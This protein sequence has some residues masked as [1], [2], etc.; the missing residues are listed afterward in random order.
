MMT[1]TTSELLTFEMSPLNL[2]T[3]AYDRQAR[4]YP[5]LLLIGPV[6]V[7]LIA[8]FSAKLT[9][10]QALGSFLVGCGGAFLLTQLARDAGKKGEKALFVEW[11]GMP[12][13]AIFRHRDTR[14]GAITKTRYHKKLAALVKEAK[15]PSVEQEQANPAAADEVYSAWS[16]FLRTNTRDTKKFAL[17]FKENVSYG[18]RR[19][20]WGLRRI[21][22]T[23][24]LI[25]LAACAGQLYRI[26]GS[27]NDQGQA[28]MGAIAFAAVCLLLWVVRFTSHW[29]RVPA[30]A[31]A[32]RLAETVE[33]LGAKTPV[34]TKG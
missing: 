29:V 5:S 27:T 1:I 33:V 19:N 6:V 22:I 34:A 9:A 30:D 14:L 17:L 24:S 15:A 21:G 4:L 13:V 11:G 20:V 28:L 31:Y 2:I 26:R 3:E 23:V 8:L 16:N 10:I 32:E 18:Y 12:S 25:S 7:S